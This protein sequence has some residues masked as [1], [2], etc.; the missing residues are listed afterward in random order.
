M[1][2]LSKG[3]NIAGYTIA[4]PIKSGEYAE[5]YRVKSPDGRTM[6][7][8]LINYSKLNRTQFDGDSK[9]LEGQIVRNLRHLN[10]CAC[11]NATDE[12]ITG[13]KF[14]CLAFDFIS[15]ETV[16]QKITREQKCSVADA[17]QIIREVLQGLDY[18][19]N[20][21][22]PVIHNEITIQN[23]ML[24]LSGEVPLAK[25]IDFG[26][27]RYLQQGISSFNYKGLNPNYLAPECFNGVFTAQSDLYAVGAVLYHLLFGVAPWFMD[28]SRKNLN[29]D[30]FVEAILAERAKPLK[31]PNANIFGLD[32]N[33]IKVITKALAQNVDRRFKSAKEF[34]QALDGEICIGI[35]LASTNPH[36]TQQKVKRKKGNGFADIAGME[37]LKEQLRY[38]VIDL[39]ENPEEYVKHN[40]T[41][42]NGILLYGPPGCGKTFFAEKFAEETGYNFQKVV[43]SDIASI[44][45]HGTQEKIRAIFD[46]ARKNTPT[47]LYFDEI[48]SMVPARDSDAGSRNGAAGEVNE[49]LSQLDNC[50]A[51]GVFVIASTNYPNQIDAAVM[52]AG[53]LEQRFYVSPPDFPARKAMF[54]IYL[55][56]RPVDL[57]IDYDNL[58]TITDNYVSADIKFIIDKASRM[59]IKN[60]LGK[61]TM[62]TLEK[63]VSESKPTV[64]KDEIKKHEN[65]RDILEGNKSERR[66]IGY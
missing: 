58:A 49:F 44:Y 62:A 39:L 42:P 5:T 53:R 7:L 64:S 27:A 21:D 30:Q 12:I 13:E 40:L 32:E 17:K 16:A 38:D 55:K 3:Q 23:I 22:N 52:R 18:L 50:G 59:T 28:L 60:K 24:E 56:G 6:F 46:E 25:I 11:D 57:G 37:P 19:H 1:F 2:T 9:V 26:H 10:I 48:N 63:V 61:I 43:T 41:L 14:C 31:L 33:L 65:I 4:F 35:P 29:E 8:K 36:D 66:R 34:L 15:G 54:E 47:I 51:T 45:V 20:L